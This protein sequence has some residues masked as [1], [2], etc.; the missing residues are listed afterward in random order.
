MSKEGA[1]LTEIIRDYAHRY[2]Q[3]GYRL[4]TGIL[5]ADSIDVNHKR[6]ERIWR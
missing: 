6:V 3:Y 2:P 1:E 4:I 5:Q